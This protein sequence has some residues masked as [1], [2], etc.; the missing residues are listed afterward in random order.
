MS[1]PRP[2]T[3]EIRIGG[4]TITELSTAPKPW[5]LRLVLAAVI[6]LVLQVTV[7]MITAL[8]LPQPLSLLVCMISG[9]YTPYL[10]SRFNHG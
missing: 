7:I 9:A 10:L 5:L 4:G 8:Y 3:A 6:V 2:T 1:N